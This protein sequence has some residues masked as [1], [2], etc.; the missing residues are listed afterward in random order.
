[1]NVDVGEL[2]TLGD[3][4]R[5]VGMEERVV[6]SGTGGSCRERIEDF[7]VMEKPSE[8]TYIPLTMVGRCPGCGD[9]HRGKRCPRCGSTLSKS[10][11]YPSYGG[12][13]GH[14]LFVLE[15]Y[16]WDTWKAV[17]RIGRELRRRDKAFGIAGMKDKRAVTSQRVTVRGVPPEALRRIDVKD[18]VV[19]PLGRV[20]RKLRPG[21][22]W[23]N[24]FVI[25]VRDADV[26]ALETAIHVIKD[27]GGVPN[28]FGVQRF[29]SRR[30]VTHV[31]GKYVVKE[32]WERAIYEFLTMEFPRESEDA[33]RARR[34]LRENWG[35][36]EGAL[37][38]FP[39]FL[40]YERE[41]LEHLARYPNDYVNAF[42][43]LPYWIRRM[44]VH[45]YQSYLFNR[46]LSE[47]MR[48]GL[49]LGEP[50]EG[51][52]VRNG[53]PTIP[54]PGFRTELADG[55]PGDI[56]RS[57]LEEEGVEPSDFEIRS[58]PEISAGGDRKPALLRV[59]R[60]SAEVI[61]DDVYVV[62]FSLPR[63]GYATSFLRELM[64]PE[65]VYAD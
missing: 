6:K 13:G 3:V 59:H 60:L 42:R 14:T 46:I 43:R 5:F 53:L 49:P 37:E 9:Y 2:R 10:K 8:S 35:D 38:V 64:G 48:R 52:I 58:M 25:T 28:F 23:G 30:P 31:V 41:I 63:G 50:V 34:W 40:D 19:T 32:D 22:L 18:I 56:E 51:D 54:L 45:A 4:E 57:V 29:G 24:R 62:T 33:I 11:L 15:K 1:L 55:E 47:R 7:L 27:L 61:A 26:D 21:D 17:R 36:F 65:G 44:F 16:D 12:K 20:R 39:R